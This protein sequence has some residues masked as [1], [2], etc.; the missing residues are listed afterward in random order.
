MMFRWIRD[1]SLVGLCVLS[2]GAAAGQQTRDEAFVIEEL[3]AADAYNI[4]REA[5]LRG[6]V[7]RGLNVE[8]YF[9]DGLS[10]PSCFSGDQAIACSIQGPV[11]ALFSR[12]NRYLH[13]RLNEPESAFCYAGAF[14]SFCSVGAKFASLETGQELAE[15]LLAQKKKMVSEEPLD[16]PG[17]GWSNV[18]GFGHSLDVWGYREIP[19]TCISG[20]GDQLCR[21]VG[22]SKVKLERD[23]QA[24]YYEVPENAFAICYQGREYSFCD[25]GG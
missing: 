6:V 11:D 23:G 8:A 16:T 25:I 17:H 21:V 9:L 14:G 1:F 15:I 3:N 2:S 19:S 12:D 7:L 20:V 18:N 5:A 13:L 10:G 22:Y 4:E 24:E